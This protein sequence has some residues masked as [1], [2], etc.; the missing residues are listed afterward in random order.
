M[1]RHANPRVYIGPETNEVLLPLGRAYGVGVGDHVTS[2]TIVFTKRGVIDPV[3]S[4]WVSYAV[5]EGYARFEIPDAFRSNPE[6]FPRGFYDGVVFIDDCAIGDVEMIK[7]PS[8][9]LGPAKSIEDKCHS[10][11]EWVEPECIRPP[12]DHISC[13]DCRCRCNGDPNKYCDCSYQIKNN[14]PSCYNKV[15][16]AELAMAGYVGLDEVDLENCPL[17]EGSEVE[18]GCVEIDDQCVVVPDRNKNQIVTTQES[19]LPE[20]YIENVNECSD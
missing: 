18:Q 11:T 2:V 5:N 19:N 1:R 15:F 8:F 9:F 14:C 20:G 6:D 12:V 7:A 13:G 10:E 16:V 3:D 4:V 17:P